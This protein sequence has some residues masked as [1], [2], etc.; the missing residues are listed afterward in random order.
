MNSNQNIVNLEPKNNLDAGTFVPLVDLELHA[1][2]ERSGHKA[3]GHD[4]CWH[5]ILQ[6]LCDRSPFRHTHVF[7]PWNSGMEQLWY[8][9]NTNIPH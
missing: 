6:Y 8:E 1:R 5:F 4:P 7:E 2:K 9:N 3:T